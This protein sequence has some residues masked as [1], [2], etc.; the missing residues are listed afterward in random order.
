MACPDLHKVDERYALYMVV[1]EDEKEI[2]DRCVRI[3]F[4]TFSP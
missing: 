4:N 1:K 2:V 3:R